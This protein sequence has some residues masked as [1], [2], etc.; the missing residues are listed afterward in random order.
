MVCTLN[1]ISSNS[2]IVVDFAAK[3]EIRFPSA[4]SCQREFFYEFW[5]VAFANRRIGDAQQIAFNDKL[6][7]KKKKKKSKE[8]IQVRTS[9][10]IIKEAQLSNL[11]RTIWAKKLQKPK[12]RAKKYWKGCEGN[13]HIKDSKGQN[14]LNNQGTCKGCRR[15]RQSRCDTGETGYRA[16]E[17]ERGKAWIQ[18][19]HGRANNLSQFDS[20]NSLSPVFSF[21]PLNE[22]TFFSIWS[23]T[24]S[25]ILRLHS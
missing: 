24:S 2:L 23:E 22:W 10:D 13:L 11:K 16:K 3:W 5:F 19:I 17:K 25:L 21:R 7:A 9:R 1:L 4:S 12:T 15:G 14:L 20:V 6:S 8:K 18:W